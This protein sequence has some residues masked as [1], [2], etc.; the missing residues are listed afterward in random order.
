MRLQIRIFKKASL[1]I[2]GVLIMYMVQGQ[3]E[4]RPNILWIVAEDMSAF[5]GCYGD[6]KVYT[7]NIDR[8]AREGV[9]YTRAFTTAGV[10]APSRSVIITGMYQT[11]IGTQHMR[12]NGDPRYQPVPSYSAVIPESVKCFPEYLRMT[13]Y[14][15]SNNQKQDYQFEAP[16]TVWNENGPGASWKNKPE[17]APFFSVFNFMITHES[18]LFMRKKDSLLVDPANVTVPP[19]YPETETVRKDLARA[20]TNINILD[21]QVGQLLD[22]LTADG[23]YDKTIIIFYADHGGPLPRM[24]RELYDR[25]IHI[26]FIIRYPGAQHAGTVNNELISSVD[27]APSMLSLAGIS[28]PAHMQGKAFLGKYK[29]QEPRKYIYAARDR[30]DTEYDRV[31]AVRDNRFKYMYNYETVKPAYQE[32]QFRLDIPMMKELLS[33]YK[34]KKLNSLQASW[35]VPG[36]PEEELYDTE[37]DPH[38]MHNL[39][40][41]PAYRTKLT[42]LRTAFQ[43]WTKKY[44]DMGALREKEMISKWWNNDTTP[45]VTSKPGILKRVE[46][47]MIQCPTAGASIGFRIIKQGQV[48]DTSKRIFLSWDMGAIMNPAANGKA[49]T[50]PPEWHLYDGKPLK[51]NSGD[52]LI[53]R[54]QRIGFVHT[55]STYVQD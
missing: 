46:G 11:A 44:G 40:A 4:V 39:A 16:V 10:C 35:F 52:T 3:P 28:I 53:A 30:M 9:K 42:E 34:D 41:D 22:Q 26:P 12:T 15:C 14:Y 36:K 45:P 33:L 6:T 7:P 54:A 49:I 17:G 8:L 23:L 13:G 18:Q 20:L 37:K 21:Q 5:L 29:T 48:T 24:K 38:E 47:I 19:Y 55:E 25:G 31:R 51:L 43:N 50:A 2:S 32:I 27:F 1:L